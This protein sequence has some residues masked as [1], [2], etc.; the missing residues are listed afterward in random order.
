[1]ELTD[2]KEKYDDLLKDQEFDRLNL[3]L[4]SPNIFQI[5]RITKNE[6]RHSNFLAWLLDPNQ[7]HEL[8]GIFLKIFLREVFSSDKFEEIDQVDV[9]GLD[10]TKVQIKRE[11]EHIDLL[12]ELENITVCIENKVLSKEHGNQLTRYKETVNSYYPHTRKIFVYLTPDGT[13]SEYEVDSYEPISYGFVVESLD[14]IIAVY[15]E[16]LD[17]QVATYIRDYITTIK[18]ELVGTD[19]LS[20]KAN[21][22]YRN[23]KDLFDFILEHKSDEV[24]D[25][26]KIMV[27]ELSSRNWILGSE[28]KTYVRFL[29][30]KI[31]HLIY[32]NE[33]KMGW[34]GGES[35]LFQISV[36]PSSNKLIFNTVI[37]PS[38][39]RY[40]RARFEEILLEI[41]GFRES[42][43][44]KWLVNRDKKQKFTYE[45]L[46][47]MSD[48]EIKQN[49]NSFYDEITPIVEE[50]EEKL[51]QNEQELLDLKSVGG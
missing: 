47:W 31:K 51:I 42:K 20:E 34:K 24:D 50:V 10:L 36:R 21:K 40:N 11:W 25:L 17:Q 18:R 3:G 41:E 43:G 6:I 26:R 19:K 1:M 44:N 28:S 30:P 38:E 7:S 48:D 23:H 37:S 2:L 22:I 15:G 14:R 13:D 8:G 32:I 49:V 4:R 29:T 39:K 45:E 46:P 27:T 9:E 5:L 12:I 35:F 16:S 33:E